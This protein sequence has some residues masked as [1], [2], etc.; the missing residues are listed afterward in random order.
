MDAVQK[1]IYSTRNYHSP[2][3]EPYRAAM[4]NAAPAIY[5]SGALHKHIIWA[6]Y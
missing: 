4:S 3:S 2:S 5:F 1:H 6:D